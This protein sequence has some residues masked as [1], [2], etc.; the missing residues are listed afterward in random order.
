MARSIRKLR[1]RR[2]RRGF[3][4]IEL[5]VVVA[6]IAVLISI[7]LPSLAGARDQAKMIK[8]GSNLNQL[9]RAFYLYAGD[10][11]DY[12]CSGQSDPSKATNYPEDIE[13]QGIIGLHRVGWIA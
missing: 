1:A 10:N 9:G 7:L 5:L 4:L 2:L 11:K 13:D 12:L 8:C 6:I 3:T